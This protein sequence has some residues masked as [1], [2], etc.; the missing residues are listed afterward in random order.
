MMTFILSS[1]RS[2][3]VFIDS[4]LSSIPD[5]DSS[6]ERMARFLRIFQ[7]MRMHGFKSTVVDKIFFNVYFKPILK[8]SNRK[9]YF[10]VN[11][12]LKGHI[13]EA[14]KYFPEATYIHLIRDPRSHVTSSINWVNNKPINTF[15]KLYT[16]FW[17]PR[18]DQ[19]TLGNDISS[20]M[21]E[22]AT[23]NWVETNKRYLSLKNKTKNY[24]LFKFE[25][26]VRSPATFIR[27]ILKFSRYPHIN[28]DE[29]MLSK[30]IDRA[31]K[32]ES[33]KSF[34]PWAHWDDRFKHYLKHH[35]GSLMKEFGYGIDDR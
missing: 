8:H 12:T 14:V 11:P 25:D 35:C 13:D 15:F 10:E 2:G 34:P 26:L 1:G 5:I 23:H 6:H 33:K 28:I 27:E 9:Y 19:F 7:S 17:T 20:K 22:I 18:P 30:I 29:I 21:F 32:N 3:T 31:S 4:A 24:G 16:P